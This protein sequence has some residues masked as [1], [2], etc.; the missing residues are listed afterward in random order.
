MEAALCSLYSFET[1]LCCEACCKPRL[2]N[3]LWFTRCIIS[4]SKRHTF[5]FSLCL[6]MVRICSNKMTE[7]LG[8]SY[9][10]ADRGMCV[11]SFALFICD[12]MAAQMTV[13]LYLLPTSFCMISTGRIPPCSL[14]TTGLRSAKK[15]SPLLTI[16]GSRSAE[17]FIRQQ[18]QRNM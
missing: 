9:S 16:I 11:G 5:S 14:P 8:K 18:R 17:K 1:P 10:A 12:V 15:I 2:T 13:G 6:S 4:V 3:K 7:S